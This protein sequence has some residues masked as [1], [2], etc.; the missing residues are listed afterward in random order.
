MTDSVLTVQVIEA[1]N[2]RF[3]GISP[4]VELLCENQIIET[5]YKVNDANPVYKEV[6][7]FKIQNGE[8]DLVIY[9]KDFRPNNDHKLL[10]KGYYSLNNLKDQLRKD[11][12]VDLIDQKTNSNVG[13]VHLELQWIYSKIKYFED[14]IFQLEK[15]LENNKTDLNS[16]NQSLEKLNQPFGIFEDRSSLLGG[17]NLHK[18]VSNK[19]EN[20]AFGIIGGDV[21]WPLL[22]KIFLVSYFLVAVIHM[23]LIPDFLNVSFI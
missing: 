21:K 13:R 12:I 2:L 10:A 8:D 18:R 23:F 6:F 7:T 14:I 17:K 22:L 16:Y 1:M 20:I 19:I 5:D 11:V 3:S 9:L 15:E 4:F